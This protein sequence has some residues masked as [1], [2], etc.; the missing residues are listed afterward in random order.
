MSAVGRITESQNELTTSIDVAGARSIVR[1]LRG[2]D[3]QL[4]AGY[5]ALDSIYDAPTTEA[6]EKIAELVSAG[7]ARSLVG[8]DGGG[9]LHVVLSGSGTSGRF[10]FTTARAMNRTFG[11]CLKAAAHGVVRAHFHYCNSGGDRG[12][13]RE[14]EGAEDSPSLALADL[15]AVEARTGSSD[16]LLLVGISCGFSAGYVGA[17]LAH[18]MDN[19]AR[20]AG[21]VA[22]GFNPRE[23]VQRVQLPG[24]GATFRDVLDRL[25]EGDVHAEQLRLVWSPVVGPEPISGSTRMKGGSATKVLLDT[26]LNLAIVSAVQRM[27]E[28]SD[29]AAKP[30]V[31]SLLA[32]FETASRCAYAPA[33]VAQL[34]QLAKLAADALRQRGRLVYLGEGPAGLLGIVDASVSRRQCARNSSPR[35]PLISSPAA[36]TCCSL[37]CAR[38]NALQ[39][40][41]PRSRM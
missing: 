23:R 9:A 18:A 5:G 34:A 2:S 19:P 39:R 3:A 6:A 32:E 24:W 8:S 20:Y 15:Q 7:L 27:V 38:R 35:A 21:V 12:L 40:M 31:A 41:A 1:L 13:L 28:G 10:A 11:A 22:L 14:S 30:S 16:R 17:Q 4:F 29:S 25:A 37:V 26:S 33:A 36:P